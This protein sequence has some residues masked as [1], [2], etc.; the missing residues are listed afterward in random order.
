VAIQAADILGFSQMLV[1][2]TTFR[3]NLAKIQIWG[4]VG[5]WVETRKIVKH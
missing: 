4:M 1:M 5:E 2:I 3:D